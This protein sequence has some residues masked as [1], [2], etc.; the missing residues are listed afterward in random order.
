MREPKQRRRKKREVLLFFFFFF[1]SLNFLGARWWGVGGWG[2]G[3]A[4]FLEFRLMLESIKAL[5]HVRILSSLAKRKESL[6]REW[7]GRRGGA[8]ESPTH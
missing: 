1:S 6:N 3:R 7:G 4:A 5:P 8:P 2:G